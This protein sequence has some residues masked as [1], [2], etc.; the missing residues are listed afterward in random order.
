MLCVIH[1]ATDNWK[2]KAT[3]A[4]YNITSDIMSMRMIIQITLT[5][6]LRISSKAA[7]SCPADFPAFWMGYQARRGEDTIDGWQTQ[8]PI[9][10]SAPCRG[11]ITYQA[12]SVSQ[13]QKPD[14]S[15]SLRQHV[16]QSFV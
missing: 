13:K 6:S 14:I 12:F 10:S 11:Q 3:D 4:S 2:I 5:L 15:P 1:M 7:S 9:N 8:R 16:I